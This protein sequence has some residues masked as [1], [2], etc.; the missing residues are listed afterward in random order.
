MN[1]PLDSVLMFQIGPVPIT[2]AI[3]TTWVIMAVLVLG[4]YLLT[5]RMETIPGKRQ[6]ALELIV[7]TLDTQIRE[8]TGASPDP[9]AASSARC[10][11]SSSWRTGLRSCRVW[12]RRR[13]SWKPMRRLPPWF[14][15]R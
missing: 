11:C 13:R 12:N 4:G 14:S 9:T 10:S 8:T 6:A 15:S 2:Q 5:R 3:V 7:A 1:S